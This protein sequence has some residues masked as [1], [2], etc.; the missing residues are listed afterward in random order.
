M[1]MEEELPLRLSVTI[2]KYMK[3]VS[4]EVYVLSAGPYDRSS[5]RTNH[6]KRI[7]N[8]I[9]E[10]TAGTHYSPSQTYLRR[11]NIY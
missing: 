2:L 6:P 11:I 4:D 3:D 9:K 7:Q 10:A 8:I 5:K 1:K